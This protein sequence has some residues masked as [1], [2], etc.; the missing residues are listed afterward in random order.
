MKK[1]MEEFIEK[2]EAELKKLLAEKREELR[3]FRFSMKGSKI[4]NTKLGSQVRKDIAR[5]LF[6]LGN[7]NKETVQK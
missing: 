3:D 7:K 4:R 6:V 2:N 1:T 5:I